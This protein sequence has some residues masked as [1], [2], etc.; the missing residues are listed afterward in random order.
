MSTISS[1]AQMALSGAYVVTPNQ[2]LKRHLETELFE[3]ISGEENSAMLAP[4]M[5]SFR[6]FVLFLWEELIKVDEPISTSFSLLNDENAYLIWLNIMAKQQDLSTLVPPTEL[7]SSLS[8][9]FKRSM[10]WQ[11]KDK[12]LM[13]ETLEQELFLKWKNIFLSTIEKQSLLCF[14]QALAHI[15]QTLEQNRI[16]LPGEVILFA[17]DEKPPLVGKLFESLEKAGTKLVTSDYSVENEST[18]RQSYEDNYLQLLNAAEWAKSIVM[19][20]PTARIGIV[21]PELVEKRNEILRVFNFVFEPQVNLPQVNRYTAPFNFSA[22]VPLSSEPVIKFALSLLSTN[23]KKVPIEN[24]ISIIRSPFIAGAIDEFQLRDQFATKLLNR[25]TSY[26]SIIELIK[27]SECPPLL[28]LALGKFIKKW[29]TL[30]TQRLPSEWINAFTALLNEI[31]WPGQRELDSEEYQAYLQWDKLAQ[32]VSGVD[33]VIGHVSDQ[34]ALSLVHLL[35]NSIVFQPKTTDSPIQVLG[36]LETAGLKF[37]YLWFLDADD[38]T[39]P[40]RPNPSP[41]I[42]DWVQSK[43]LMPHSSPERE[44]DFCLRFTER[45]K[46][47]ARHVVFSYKTREQDRDIKP[48]PLIKNLQKASIPHYQQP[49]LDYMT[50]SL[51][52][53]S[54]HKV[55]EERVPYRGNKI[56]GGTGTIQDQLYCPFKAFA[57]KR[58]KAIPLPKLGI[59]IDH[60]QQGNLL[61]DSLNF[62][63]ERII[64]HRKLVSMSEIEMRELIKLSVDSAMFLL[65]GRIELTDELLDLESERLNELL[66]EWMGFEKQRAPFVVVNNEETGTL[67]LAGAKI[68]VRLDR[69]DILDDSTQT[70]EPPESFV[71]DYKKGNCS[72]AG[73]GQFISK[74]QLPMYALVKSQEYETYGVCYAQIQKGDPKLIGFSDN[75]AQPGL[76]PLEKNRLGLPTEWKQTLKFWKD[77]LSALARDFLHGVNDITPDK[78]TGCKYCELPILCRFNYPD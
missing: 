71:V 52:N 45:L 51:S 15:T 59:G 65:K 53:I 44:L 13:L 30:L 72:L 50:P 8:S 5:F 11:L 25:R 28:K 73:M 69:R 37:D 49:T 54:V 55:E 47:S 7:A 56:V 70:N 67:N 32:K 64:S 68:T 1:I 62:L 20:D 26:F 78:N 27:R 38:N 60:I 74:P 10:L 57:N 2:R 23:L 24:L 40:P 43:S 4:N 77:E 46:S 39:W 33:N 17:F 34:L 9:A 21:C 76:M 19:K 29:N 18:T 61:H 3:Y 63:W 41:W 31:G 16:S 42:S 75:I 66:N 58:L 35:A 36:T 12:D 22:G 48:S 14:E 6:E